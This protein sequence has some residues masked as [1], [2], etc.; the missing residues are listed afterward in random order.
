[1]CGRYPLHADA[2]VVERAFGIEEF[3]FTPHELTPRFNTS[4]LKFRLFLPTRVG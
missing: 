2:K 4:G 3:S 1:M